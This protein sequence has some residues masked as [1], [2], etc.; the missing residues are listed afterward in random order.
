M[1]NGKVL[2]DTYFESGEKE[3]KFGLEISPEYSLIISF[4]EGVGF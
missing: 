3:T 1:K 4:V 2:C